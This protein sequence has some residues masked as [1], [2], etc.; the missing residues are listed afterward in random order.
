MCQQD[1]SLLTTIIILWLDLRVH[2][3]CLSV[4]IGFHHYMHSFTVTALQGFVTLIPRGVMFII[5]VLKLHLG[6]TDFGLDSAW[7]SLLQHSF[8][9]SKGFA[10][11]G[12][13]HFSLVQHRPKFNALTDSK[14]PFQVIITCFG[15]FKKTFYCSFQQL[16][17]LTRI[18]LAII[19]NELWTNSLCSSLNICTLYITHFFF[20]NGL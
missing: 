13:E 20:R 9:I 16:I 17:I 6:V 19:V 11:E 1:Q 3:L 4:A 2:D 10:T 5:L 8:C 7:T 14:I 12:F 18:F 15:V